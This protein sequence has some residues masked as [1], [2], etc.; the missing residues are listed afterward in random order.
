MII[1][2]TSLKKGMGQT[3]TTVN[4]AAMISELIGETTII[5]D[6]N[7]Y[8]YDI[9]Y[10][11]S[12]S[13]LTKG[14]DEFINLKRTDMLN[15]DNFLS[16]VKKINKNIHIMTSNDCFEIDGGDI[17]SLK[18]YLKKNYPVTIIDTIS[19][20]N[21]TTDHFMNIS[22]VI[23]LVANQERK[24]YIEAER[25]EKLEKYKDKLV[26]VINR[27]M[28]SYGNNRMIYTDSEITKDLKS[29]GFDDNRIHKLNFDIEIMNDC[30]DFSILSYV[31]ANKQTDYLNQ[32][33][34]IS[35]SILTQ[36]GKYD[37]EEVVEKKRRGIL[38]GKLNFSIF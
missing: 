28:E 13:N 3:V 36:Y 21:K 20:L 16:C 29:L 24:M 15:E 6:T 27:Y 1:S 12:N 5:I 25:F 37:F 2:V 17:S 33:N 30:N 10:Y 38:R 35:K 26:F 34:Q 19:S 4:L 23:V 18:K 11:L 32:L 7:R 9:A 31:L 14:L 22:D 8:Y